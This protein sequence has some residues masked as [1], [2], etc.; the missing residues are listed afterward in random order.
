L[1]Q[2]PAKELGN[3]R[4]ST[5]LSFQSHDSFLLIGKERDGGAWK[6]ARR[7]ERGSGTVIWSETDWRKNVVSDEMGDEE[8]SEPDEPDLHWTSNGRILTARA[9]GDEDVHSAP[10]ALYFH[11]DTISAILELDD[12]VIIGDR[13][14]GV[15][16]VTF[17]NTDAPVIGGDQPVY[18]SRRSRTPLDSGYGRVFRS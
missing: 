10:M 7:W 17:R 14:G 5:E 16:F 6:V 9:T 1:W 8:I 3:Y 11:S 4:L 18:P 15:A 13:Q 12:R 2:I